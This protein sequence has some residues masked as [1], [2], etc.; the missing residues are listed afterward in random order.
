MSGLV[1]CVPNFSEGRDRKVIDAIAAAITSVEGAEVLDIDMGG[2]TNR[3]VVTFVAPPASVGDAAFAG[4]ARAAELID[5]RAHAGAHPRMGAT[6]VLPFVPVSG[7]NMDDCIA[8]AHTTGERIGA[9][10]GI[11]VWFYEEAARSSEFRNLARVRAGEYEGLAE[12][13]D[14]GAPDAGPAKFNA[15]SGATAVGAREFLIAWNINLNTRDRTYANE[16]AY[17]LRERGRWKRS[18]SPDAFYYKGDV[19]HFAN[20]EFPCGNCDFTGADFDALAAHYAEVHGGDLTEAYCA[21]G[22]DPRAL[23]GKPVYKDGR[24]TNLKGIGWEIPEYGCAQLSFNVTNFRTTPLHEVFDAACEE[25]RKRGIRVTGSEIVGLV[26]WEVL[27]Q[28]AVHYLRRMGKSP[29]LPVPD[30]A[31]AAIQSLG[32]RDVADFNPASKVLGMPKQE[33]EL[34][35]RVTYDFVD[36]V[37]RDSPAPGGGS[38]AALAGALGAALGTMVANLSATKGTQAANYDALAGIAERGQAVKEALVAGVDADT[39]AFDGVIAAMRMPKDSDEQRATRDAALEAGYRD[40]T[41]VPLATVG[42][43][44][45]ALAVCGD[46]APLMDAAMAS[47]VGSGALLAHAGARAA[48]YNVRIN[49]KEIPDEAFCRETS[50]ALE[51]LLGE[52]DAH[53]AAVAEAVEATLR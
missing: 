53:A 41:A 16:L 25:A 26:P 37:S 28:A 42:Q 1:E 11:P 31:A 49:L 34:V 3:T 43:C 7:V 21:R 13:L 5:M 39:S 20:G 12:R 30:L 9:E 38:V 19:V 51:T 15:R 52:C 2:E 40:A 46:M 4:V 24:F 50:V 18:G 14:G 44:R 8:I 17:E 32:L 36:E 48:G 6:D 29:G 35:N 27:R 22:L 45:D 10:L 47:D 23:V 33:G